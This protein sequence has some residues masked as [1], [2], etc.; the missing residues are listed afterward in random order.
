MVG[1]HLT[2]GGLLRPNAEGGLLRVKTLDSQPPGIIH[3][4]LAGDVH[5]LL[6]FYVRLANQPTITGVDL[7][8]K[9]VGRP[10]FNETRVI[11]YQPFVYI[12]NAIQL[13]KTATKYV[14]TTSLSLRLYSNLKFTYV[15]EYDTRQHSHTQTE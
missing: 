10:W 14:K 13:T 4:N 1:S 5:Q 6:F 11:R 8:H 9:N 15:I 2:P 3:N 7:C 12:L